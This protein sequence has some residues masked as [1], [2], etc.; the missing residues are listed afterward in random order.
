MWG[1]GVAKCFGAAWLCGYRVGLLWGSNP[2]RYPSLGSARK[3]QEQES[4]GADFPQR[5]SR[6][7]QRRMNIVS[8][9]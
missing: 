6:R 1:C 2:A 3:I 9:L 8:I 5:S 4:I 7:F